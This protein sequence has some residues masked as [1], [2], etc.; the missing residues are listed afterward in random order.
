MKNPGLKRITS[1][2]TRSHV[3]RVNG[4]EGKEAQGRKRLNTFKARGS[5]PREIL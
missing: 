4:T 5:S 1:S 2:F 3:M